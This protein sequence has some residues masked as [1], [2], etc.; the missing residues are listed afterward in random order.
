MAQ[1]ALARSGCDIALS[2][3]G[4]AGPLGGTSAKPVG[5]VHFALADKR[6]ASH[7]AT[8]L[9]LRSG[10]QHIRYQATK[11]ALTLLNRHIEQYYLV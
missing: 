11:V 3:T 10:R 7:H 5:T 1:G 4:I 2:I 8:S 9:Q 6:H